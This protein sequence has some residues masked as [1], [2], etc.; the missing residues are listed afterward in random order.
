M[1]AGCPVI[2]TDAHGNRDFSFAGKNCLMVDQEDEQ[3]L[4]E[5]IKKMQSSK[6]L[7][8][9]LSAEGLKTARKFR[10]DAIMKIA[11]KFYSEVT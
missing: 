4:S 9:R 3:G 7:R 1:A 6:A 2:C 10:W 11:E 5:A 8:L